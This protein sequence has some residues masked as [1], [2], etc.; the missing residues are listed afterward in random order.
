[1]KYR[2]DIAPYWF[3]V[4]LYLLEESTVY[5]LDI[6]KRNNP[7]DV[8][9]CCHEMLEYWLMVDVEA[10]WNKLID[11]LEVTELTRT[12]ERIKQDILL[13]KVY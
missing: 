3:D 6:I 7:A 12:A 10:S 8:Q 4:G 5:K 1:M 11:V 2:D 13:G 9:S